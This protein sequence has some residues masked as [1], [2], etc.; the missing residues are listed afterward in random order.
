MDEPRLNGVGRLCE[1]AR[2]M[3]PL[4]RLILAILGTATIVE[5]ILS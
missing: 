5:K 3:W 4:L 1:F 2:E